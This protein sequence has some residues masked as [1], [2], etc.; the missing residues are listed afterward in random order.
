MGNVPLGTLHSL[1]SNRDPMFIF[2]KE[3]IN[4]QR[5]VKNNTREIP[6]SDAE[7]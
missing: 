1:P 3:S 5:F 4:E 2:D 7:A 6:T